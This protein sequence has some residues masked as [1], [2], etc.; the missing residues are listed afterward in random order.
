MQAASLG[1]ILGK[2]GPMA[3]VSSIYTSTL[4][5]Y[6]CGNATIR[7]L[8]GAKGMCGGRGLGS[9]SSQCRMSVARL[10]T[11]SEMQPHSLWQGL[12]PNVSLRAA[13]MRVMP[14]MHTWV[15]DLTVVFALRCW[16]R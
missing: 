3:T 9:H 1:T 7:L 5:W 2:S 14:L 10:T 12:P 16:Q 4:L 11:V 6:S 8:T 13:K 15:K